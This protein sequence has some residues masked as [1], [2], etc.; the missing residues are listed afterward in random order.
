MARSTGRRMAALGF[1]LG[2][3]IAGIG[4]ASAATLGGLN[5]DKLGAGTTVVA[6]CDDTIDV[7]WADGSSSPVFSGNATP[8]NSTFNVSTIK[9]TN[10][11]TDCEGMNLKVTA[12][13]SANTSL[14]NA[15]TTVSLSGGSQTITLSSAVNS[16]NIASVALTIYE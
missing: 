5:S 15:N 1:L 7:S 9:I 14:A 6:V 10:V 13:N 2:V 11:S 12:A 16:K 3:G 8:A 4:V